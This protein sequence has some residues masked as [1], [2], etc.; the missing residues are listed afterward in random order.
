MSSQLSSPA[1]AV[2]NIVTTVDELRAL[3]ASYALQMPPEVVELEILRRREYLTTDEVEKLYPLKA[4]VLRKKRADGEGPEYIK[5]GARTL[6]THKAI[7]KYL[8]AGR[9]KTLKRS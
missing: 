3:L 1:T 8:E 2:I 7:H 9:Q 4:S 6:Y 5:D